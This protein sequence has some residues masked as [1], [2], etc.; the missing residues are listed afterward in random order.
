MSFLVN[1]QR[2]HWISNDTRLYE[3]PTLNSNF[4]GYFKYGASIQIIDD[5]N[6]GWV[7]VKADNN[8]V[9]F[10]KKE[11]ITTKLNAKDIK[12]I[13]HENPIILGN[14]SYYGG[15]HLFVLVAGLKLRSEPNANAKI[16]KIA[17]TGMPLSVSYVPVNEEKWVCVDYNKFTLKKCIGNRPILND[18]FEVFNKIDL[19]DVQERRKISERI[20]EL[21]WNSGYEHLSKAYT[22]YAEV[23]KQIDD[24]EL[25]EKTEMYLL[26]T[27][28][29]AKKLPFDEI[30]KLTKDSDF[31]IKNLNVNTFYST[32]LELNE[33]YNNPT[34]IEILRMVVVFI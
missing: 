25:I 19:S 12:T 33:Y 4:Y 9:G 24:P 18:L 23:V 14:D 7:Q 16:A 11:Y 21:S 17:S 22:T 34:K 10:V 29:L 5:P 15:N 3:N 26:L 27:N 20:V 2:N 32:Y 30:T 8:D 6:S 31:S 1:G 28:G 13:D